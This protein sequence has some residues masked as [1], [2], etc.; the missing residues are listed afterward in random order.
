MSAIKR[1]KIVYLDMAVF[2]DKGAV[3]ESTDR[4]NAFSYLHGR[5]NLLG[6]LEEVLEGQVPGFETCVSVGAEK[7]FG[8]SDSELIID[9]PAKQFTSDA[10]LEEGEFVQAKGPNGIMSFRVERVFNDHVRLNAN[11]P[12][13]NK[14][15]TFTLKV[16][17]VREAHKDEVRHKRPHPGGHHLMVSD[18]SWVGW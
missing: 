6:A 11:H 8:Y 16:L 9:V 3:I 4:Q 5:G 15:L 12:L 2:D 10:K 18:S 13:A 17:E 1:N 14:S 7:S